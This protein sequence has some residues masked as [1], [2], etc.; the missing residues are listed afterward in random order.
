MNIEDEPTQPSTP[1]VLE[2]EPESG[3]R[4]VQIGHSIVGEDLSACGSPEL[5]LRSAITALSKA[6]LLRVS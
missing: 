4:P 3:T 2:P 6:G 5:L 1:F